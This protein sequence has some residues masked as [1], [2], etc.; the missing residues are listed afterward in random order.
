MRKLLI[1][2]GSPRKNGV[3]SSVSSMVAD[4]VRKFD[5]ETEIVNLCDLRI[6]GCRACMS[7]KSTG[8][9]AQDDDMTQMYDRIRESDM[10]LFAAPIYFGAECAQMKTMVDRFY[11]MIMD[12]DGQRLVNFGKV[13]KGATLLVCGASDGQMIYGGVIG[14]YAKIFKSFDI[15]DFTG[16]ILTGVTPDE[17]ADSDKVRDFIESIEFQAE[18]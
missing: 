10:V 6:N 8:R 1:V 15:A 17:V 16:Y 9:C 13:K 4:A 12:K 14:R 7:C 3:C 18:M 2:N 5:Y 11:A